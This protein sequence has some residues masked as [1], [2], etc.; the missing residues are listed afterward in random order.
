MLNIVKKKETNMVIKDLKEKLIAKKTKVKRYEQRISQ[1]RQNHLFQVNQKKVYKD[2]NGKNGIKFW[3]DNWSIRKEHSQH[4][5]WLKGC[6][7]VLQCM[8][9]AES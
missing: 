1:F 8:Q 7:K 6:R 9:Y 3:S 5:E 4:H 2:P